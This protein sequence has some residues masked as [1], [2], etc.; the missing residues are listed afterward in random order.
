MKSVK[1]PVTLEHRKRG[2]TFLIDADGDSVFHRFGG[3]LLGD[4]ALALNA[5]DALVEA[6]EVGLECLDYLDE[7]FGR[8]HP[9]LGATIDILRAAL[10]LVRGEAEN[11]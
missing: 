9:N 4:V 1:T 8:I 5:H 2:E 10:A 6:C 11:A 3:R 7:N